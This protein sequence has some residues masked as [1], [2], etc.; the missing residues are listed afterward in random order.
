ML[1]SRFCLNG[2][3]RK[4]SILRSVS[5]SISHLKIK[6]FIGLEIF[7]IVSCSTRDTSPWD[8]SIITMVAP[9]SRFR[10]DQSIRNQ[11]RCFQVALL[12]SNWLD[13]V[14]WQELSC[15]VTTLPLFTIK[16]RSWKRF[17]QCMILRVLKREK[18]TLSQDS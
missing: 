3:G 7:S 9:F 11:K 10:L 4:I 16:K 5:A 15:S 2:E 14:Y 1:L 8:F 6:L 17:S 13:W 18:Q 12:S